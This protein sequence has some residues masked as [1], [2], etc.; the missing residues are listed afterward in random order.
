MTLLLSE[1]DVRAALD[2]REAIDALDTAFRS[3]DSGDA[4]NR[5]RSH[6]YSQ[7]SDGRHHLFKTMDGAVVPLGVHALRLS[8]DIVVEERSGMGIKRVKVPA[9]PGERY[10][11]LVM[12]FSI[13][14]L[15]PLA[16]M[17][18]GYL[19]RMR[20]GAT[21]ALAA[22]HLAEPG[23]S[24]VA[25]VGTGWQA[26][27]QLIGLAADRAIEAVRV[28]GPTDQHVV[29][30]A[31]VFSD[32]LGL[33]ITPA[34]NVRDA[35]EGAHTVAL[36]TN[37]F[38]PVIDGSWLTPGQHV[39]SVQGYEL[40]NATL[41]RADVIAVRS[42]EPSTY[43][44]APGKAPLEVESEPDIAEHIRA[45]MVELGSVVA[46]REGRRDASQ[47]T[48]FTGS[49]TGASAGLG[50]QFAAVGHAVYE[51]ARALSLGRELPTEWFTQSGRP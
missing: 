44:H 2:M 49:H 31:M 3:L 50:I 32:R 41:E 13:E 43:H 1:D 23:S 45:K 5:P 22:R 38:E 40:D 21:S 8:S 39:G 6:S 37:S 12:L 14:E 36:A 48:L 35:I 42:L 25:I 4:V 47:V 11:G 7:L 10:V 24:R 33:E 9:A 18:D 29:E 46:G 34:P 26:G 30:F 51:R 19:Q 16:I 17:P 28:F 15:A 20:V 27:A